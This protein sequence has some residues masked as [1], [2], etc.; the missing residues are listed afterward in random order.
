MRFSAT[1]AMMVVVTFQLWWVSVAAAQQQQ[2][3][4]PVR[5][6]ETPIALGEV[7]VKPPSGPDWFIADRSSRGLIFLKKPQVPLHSFYAAALLKEFPLGAGGP[8]DVFK[9]M[10]ADVKRRGNDGGRFS[11]QEFEFGKEEER[12]GARCARY[13]YKSEDHAARGAEGKVL[14]LAAVGYLCVHPH[15]PNMYLDVYYSERGGPQPNSTALLEEG[16]RF[17][18]GLSF[19]IRK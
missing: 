6:S 19:A 13:A 8:E 7:L 16:E 3:F 1:V 18:D 14:L 17:L 2:R 12:S 15:T 11:A 10:Q 5:D 4:V 9:L